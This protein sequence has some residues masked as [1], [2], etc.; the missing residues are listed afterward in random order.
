MKLEKSLAKKYTEDLHPTVKNRFMETLIARGVF[1]FFFISSSSEILL[2]LTACLT[3]LLDS[4]IDTLKSTSIKPS[5]LSFA[6]IHA[7]LF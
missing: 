5:L 3:S 1:L 4:Y 6:L 2:F 7:F